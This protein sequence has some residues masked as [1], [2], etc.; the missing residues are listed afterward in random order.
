MAEEVSEVVAA[1]A[2]ALARDALARAPAP[3]EA[4]NDGNGSPDF[5][6]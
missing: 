3:V 2:H 6:Q 5:D 4:D 1:V